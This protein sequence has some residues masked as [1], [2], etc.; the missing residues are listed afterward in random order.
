MRKKLKQKNPFWQAF[1]VL[2]TYTR[3]DIGELD[4]VRVAITFIKTAPPF[5]AALRLVTDAEEKMNGTRQ[6]IV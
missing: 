4:D 6:P 3:N 2:Y 5:K 1:T